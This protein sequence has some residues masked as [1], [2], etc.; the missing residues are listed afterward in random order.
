M[1]SDREESTALEIETDEEN[2]QKI[3]ERKSLLSGTAK[4]A[5]SPSCKTMLL[6]AVLISIAGVLFILM[7]IELW[8]DYGNVINTQTLFSP[9]VHSIMEK[10]PDGSSDTPQLTK[11]YNDMDCGFE[12]N[13]TGT[14]LHC[15][16]NMPGNALILP[17]MSSGSDKVSIEGNRFCVTWNGKNISRCVRLII[18]SI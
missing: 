13:A 7:M 10:C 1:S 4:K 11:S 8:G 6:K 3:H 2:I 16:G 14:T 5:K 15:D 12:H 17:S 18:Y 9:K